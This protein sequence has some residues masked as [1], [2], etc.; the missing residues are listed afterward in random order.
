MKIQHIKNEDK[1]LK[2]CLEEIKMSLSEEKS[3]VNYL[4]FHLTEECRS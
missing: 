2:Q 1:Q 3:H 4:S